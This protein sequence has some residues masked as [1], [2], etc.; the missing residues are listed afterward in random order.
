MVCP[1]R[2]GNVMGFVAVKEFIQ[3]K[4]MVSSTKSTP[5]DFNTY[6]CSLGIWGDLSDGQAH[7][8]S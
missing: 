5:Q 7:E 8:V 3:G 2:Q 4:L 6:E 1:L